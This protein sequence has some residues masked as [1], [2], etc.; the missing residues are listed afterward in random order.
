MTA[1]KVVIATGIYPPE[2]GGPAT[3]A[4]MLV[5]DLPDHGLHP[6]LATFRPF[7]GLPQGVRHLFYLRRL[8]VAARDADLLL[9]LDPVSVGLPAL[10]AAR[11]LR[12]PLALR[13]GGDY[14]WEQGVQRF[15]VGEDLDAFLGKRYG[16]R[17]E[18]LR[19]IERRVAH[20]AALV[21]VPSSYL[22]KVLRRWGVVGSRIRIIPNAAP[23][24]AALVSRAEAR[25][26]LG[27]HGR[28]VVSAGRLLRL[29]GFDGLIDA[30]SDLRPSFPD[31]RL[32]IVGSGP[33]G[34][35]LEA[36]VLE[37]G[38]QDV[39]RLTGR[40]P[41][42]ETLQW[43]QAAD[44][45]VLNSAA[46]GL[47]HVVLE[48]M[49]AGTPVIATRVGGLPEIIEEGVTGSLVLPGDRLELRHAIRHAL[50][51]PEQLAAMAARARDVRHRFTRRE[52]VR[53]TAEALRAAR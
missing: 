53:R 13:V 41:H 46:E 10:L 5:Q 22:A 19:G 49:A 36:R 11:L 23:A 35:A 50:E 28:W 26:G 21:I 33:E 29:K 6:E 52:M 4:R 48:A 16:W 7:L 44:V 17:I 37:A 47:P 3:C 34:A 9:A 24:E 1:G 45:F 27:I 12:R 39:V 25:Q 2:I 18:L 20:A 31:L 30:A 38:L 14:A 51:H 8:L 43:I 42:A 32:A 15:G 40:L